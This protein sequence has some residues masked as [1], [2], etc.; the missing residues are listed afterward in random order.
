GIPAGS[1]FVRAQL[2]G[3]DGQAARQQG[4]DPVVGTQTT[5]CHN[6][7]AMEAISSPLFL[8]SQPR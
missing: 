2:L 6:V 4:C 8:E 3:P 5:Y 1:K 7:L